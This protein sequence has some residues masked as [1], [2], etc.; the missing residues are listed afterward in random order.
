MS[1]TSVKVQ[2][3]A[4]IDKGTLDLS[5]FSTTYSINQIPTAS[6][7][8]PAGRELTAM[9]PS[10]AHQ[11]GQT[12]NLMVPIK[13]YAKLTPIA[14]VGD[15]VAPSGTRMLFDG[16]IVG[17]GYVRTP[18][19]LQL[20]IA[21][22]HWLVALNHSSTT[23]ETSHPNN[24]TQYS[25]NASVVG[26]GNSAGGTMQTSNWCQRTSAQTLVT[27]ASLSDLW[28]KAIK[29][30]FVELASK[31]RMFI[32]ELGVNDDTE[33]K[34]KAA[35]ERF[36]GD[37]LTIDIGEADGFLVAKRIA[38]DLAIRG[39]G[40]DMSNSMVAMAQTTF[41][42]KLVGDLSPKYK[43]SIV[44]FPDKAKVV[45]LIFGLRQT[46]ATINARDLIFTRYNTQLIRP[47]RAV[48]YRG[49]YANRTGANMREGDTP[50]PRTIGGLYIGRKDGMVIIRQAPRWAS[51]SVLPCMYSSGAT[52]G[53]INIK[54]NAVNHPGGG[55]KPAGDSLKELKRKNSSIL[56]RLAH[57]DYV[58]ECL[59]GRVG[60]IAGAVRLDI[61]PGSSIRFEGATSAFMAGT[62][63]AGSPRYA[64]VVST[65]LYFDAENQ[66]AG[67]GFRL[68]HIRN[69]TENNDD[70]SSVDRH[71]LYS[72]VWKG[73][74]LV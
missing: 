12:D 45:P 13:V 58:M 43:F 64:T 42:D 6:A 55:S 21:M 59:V 29:P 51:E 48:G 61:C 17:T 36:T 34:C 63:F 14:A 69:E 72:N 18:H 23:S 7:M 53:G 31:N 54:G 28:G 65:R 39:A 19:G 66:E 27:T 40:A 22:V 32:P 16:F 68:T 67:T 37:K 71:P 10:L 41:W 11:I 70:S 74:S 9:T 3:W 2:L 30:W 26:A 15:H 49:D 1:H 60:E 35:L 50:P 24:P 44:P 46:S 47:I 38:D 73:E 33:G 25:F 5:A 52:G 57:T 8:L 62:E 4:E 20:S 56:Y